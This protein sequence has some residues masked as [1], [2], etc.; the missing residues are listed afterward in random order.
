MVRV[1]AYFGQVL[2]LPPRLGIA[3]DK[4]PTLDQNRTHNAEFKA[5]VIIETISSRKTIHEIAADRVFIRSR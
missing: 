5:K 1:S 4:A 2:P 3:P